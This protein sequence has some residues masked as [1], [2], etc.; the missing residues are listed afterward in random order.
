VSAKNRFIAFIAGAW[1]IFGLAGCSAPKDAL[2]VNVETGQLQGVRH[3]AVVAFKG[4]PFAAPPVGELRWRA[5]NPPV[6]WEGVRAADSYGEFCA[7]R[8]ADVL[9]FELTTMSEDCLTLNIWTPDIEKSARL[10]VM[11]WIHGGGFVQGSGNVPRL[12]STEMAEQGVVLVTVNYRLGVFGFLSHP[13]LSE[14]QSGELLGNYGLLDL[15]AA[16]QWVQRNIESFGGDPDNVT[17]F[18]ESAGG[19]LVNYLM[20][21]PRSEGLFNKAISQSA[22]VGLAPDA[23]IRD[24]SGFQIPGE[25][26]GKAYAKRAGVNKSDDVVAALRAMSTEELVAALDPNARFTPVV[27]GDLIPDLVGV[28]FADGKQH[29][30]PYMTGGVSWE[31]ALGRQIG[32]GFS[33]DRMVKLI[34][35]ADRERLYPGLDETEVAD[36]VFGDLI[37]LSQ[38]HYLGDQ[39]DHVSSPSWQYFLSYLPEER[40]G[41]QPGVAH[42][43]DIA[44][45]MRTLDAEL[46]TVS[47]RDREVSE[48]MNA[49]WVQFAKT[50]NPNRESLPDWP[51]YTEAQ[52]W[53]I[54][55]GDEVLVHE[56][57]LDERIEYHK[58]RGK[59]LLARARSQ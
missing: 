43:D 19:A 10:P 12:N 39:M 25:K 21:I 42:A 38:A 44:F 47:E 35:E 37:I 30:V 34:P 33:P 4:I 56:D 14:A 9:W 36:Q 28:L 1:L 22:S 46:E 3:D 18:G 15:I 17:I 32:G 40:R 49:Y 20:V 24:R 53:V 58:D 50:G 2:V 52:P 27:E 31:A 45:V 51:A 48:L 23:R 59:K 57:F 5:P 29:D 16:L 7:Q 6:A 55:F 54:E 41:H 26:I 8:R 13:A 11:V